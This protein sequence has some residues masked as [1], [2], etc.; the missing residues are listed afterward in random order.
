MILQVGASE[1]FPK[2]HGKFSM[3]IQPMIPG[4]KNLS[5]WAPVEWPWPMPWLWKDILSRRH[6]RVHGRLLGNVGNLGVFEREAW[7]EARKMANMRFRNISFRICRKVLLLFF[8]RYGPT[9]L[10]SRKLTDDSLILLLSSYANHFENWPVSQLVK[11]VEDPLP[12]RRV[13]KQPQICCED[14]GSA[15]RCYE[16]MKAKGEKC[17]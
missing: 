10:W 7:R 11:G 3:R 15:L 17:I 16:E 8:W 12:F 6:R 5:G 4:Q 2:I 9:H 13:L 14:A 1:S